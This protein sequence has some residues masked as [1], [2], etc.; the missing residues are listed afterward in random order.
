MWV[1][2]SGKEDFGLA[3]DIARSHIQRSECRSLMVGDI[4]LADAA[5]RFQRE[6]IHKSR[7]SGVVMEG[8]GVVWEIG[9]GTACGKIPVVAFHARRENDERYD[10]SFRWE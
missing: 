9:P 7:R 8:L 2:E 4:G 5:G 10:D 1:E 6:D 3:H